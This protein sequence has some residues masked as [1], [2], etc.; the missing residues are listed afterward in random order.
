VNGAPLTTGCN[1]SG[2][3]DVSGLVSTNFV[4]GKDTNDADPGIDG[5]I[6]DVR[7]YNR[8]LPGYEV[9]ALT[10]YHPMQVGTA[11]SNFRLHLQADSFSNLSDGESITNGSVWQDGS[12][13]PLG[14]GT[15]GTASGGPT[16]YTAGFG[17][18]S[19]LQ[20]DGA[21]DFFNFGSP[22]IDLNGLT[23]CG[24]YSVTA[25]QVYAGIIEKRTGTTTGAFAVLAGSTTSPGNMNSGFESYNT[26]SSYFSNDNSNPVLACFVAYGTITGTSFY[27][28]GSS[29]HTGTG[30]S[31]LV[32]TNSWP[33][34]V[35]SR[36]DGSGYFIGK[37]GDLLLYT[38]PLTDTSVYGA[39][40][41]DREIVECYLSAKYGIEIGHSCP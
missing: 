33:M 16:Y 40:Y 11:L 5:D 4:I 20:F 19:A 23:I 26:G 15:T 3:A 35:G 8:A 1:V 13:A 27:L 22:S 21:D 9:R 37:I 25:D 10:G 28:N 34:R 32:N 7:V 14:T 29:T 18:R 17:T 36:Y 6:D 24:V 31:S 38:V 30:S 41:T 12:Y 2:P 39:P